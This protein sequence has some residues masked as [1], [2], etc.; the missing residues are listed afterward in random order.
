MKILN[1]KEKYNK[2]IVSELK[3]K[4][5]YKND[6]AAPR[7]KKIVVN[8]GVGRLSQQAG[9][10]D[11]ILPAIIGDLASICG[12]APVKTTAKKSI[13]GFKTRAGQTVGLK[14]TLRRKKMRDFLE[15]LTMIVFPRVKDF[16][17]IP[18]ENVD[19]S[20]NLTIGLKEHTVFPE[21]KSEDVKIDFGM[22][23]S[24]VSNAKTKEEAIELYR[25]LG[26]PLKK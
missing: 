12:Q 6:L 24:I 17:G 16:R 20:G 5:G 14:I 8:V 23:I 22:E 7:V 26:A 25:Q 18:V 13:A 15:R 21:I 4:F 19:K 1:L 3:K 10:E 2:E 9:F 11:K